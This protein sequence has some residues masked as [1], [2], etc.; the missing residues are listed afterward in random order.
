MAGDVVFATYRVPPDNEAK[1]RA[2]FPEHWATLEQLEL[3]TADP[4]QLYRQASEAGVT[5][6]EIFRWKPGLVGPAHE[7]PEVADIWGRM[8][9]LCEAQGDLPPVDFPH[10]EALPAAHRR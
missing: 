7:I 6:V 8:I 3:V 9:E 2:L 1:L 10:Y 5:F 4:P